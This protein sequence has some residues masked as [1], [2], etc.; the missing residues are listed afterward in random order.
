MLAEAKR[1]MNEKA[2]ASDLPLIATRQVNLMVSQ[3]ASSM[4]WELE[5][6]RLK[7]PMVHMKQLHS[8]KSSTETMPFE[9]LPPV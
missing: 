5:M 6:P 8:S 1:V 2:L 9:E 3:I 7:I 4:N